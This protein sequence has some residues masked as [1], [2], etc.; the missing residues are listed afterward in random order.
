MERTD[1]H[2]VIDRVPIGKV[3]LLLPFIYCYFFVKARQDTTKHSPRWDKTTT[4]QDKTT[5]RRDNHKT[6]QDKTR[7]DKGW[8]NHV[9]RVALTLALTL[10][11]SL[12]L[13]LL[14]LRRSPRVKKRCSSGAFNVF[15]E[16]TTVSHTLR[17]TNTL[18]AR[19]TQTMRHR[20]RSFRKA[21]P[22]PQP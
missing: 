15:R 22:L 10:T 1:I 8:S 17:S 21:S 14:I 20:W 5:T 12:T 3:T 18:R 13:S 16:R 11:L 4:R 2:V 19:G 6:R 7:Q 9:L